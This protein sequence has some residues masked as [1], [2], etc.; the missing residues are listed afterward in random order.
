MVRAKW[1]VL[2]NQWADGWRVCNEKLGIR[3]GHGGTQVQVFLKNDI[4]L[5]YNQKN[6]IIKS[7]EREK[8]Q[9]WLDYTWTEQER[10]AM[11]WAEQGPREARII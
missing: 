5:K 1:E 6:K 8:L 4:I 9:I 11:N 3:T 10:N 2:S 7:G